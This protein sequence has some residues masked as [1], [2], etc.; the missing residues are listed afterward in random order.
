M[1]KKMTKMLDLMLE[2]IRES[3]YSSNFP[4]TAE[5]VVIRSSGFM[6]VVSSSSSETADT[7]HNQ[8]IT[9]VTDLL[10]ILYRA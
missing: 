8:H 3:E 9:L 7:V 1:T 6:H 10:L 4:C 5:L 2:D